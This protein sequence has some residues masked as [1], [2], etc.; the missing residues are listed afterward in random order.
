VDEEAIV[1]IVDDEFA[2]RDLVRRTVAS[3]GL[4]AECFASG[5]EFLNAYDASRVACLVTDLRLP[6]LTGQEI[7][8][9]LATRR[10]MLPTVVIS[11][12]GDIPSAV[13]AMEVGAITFLEK[14]CSL[15]RLQESIQ[16]AITRAKWL[17]EQSHQA[18]AIQDR[19]S[20]LND[21]EHI[22]MRMIAEGKPDKAIASRLDVSIRTVQ[23]RRASLM[24]KLGV[25][26]RAQLIRITPRDAD[27][28]I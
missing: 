28:A 9:T 8:E 5:R 18:R 12:Y 7:L 14:P 25:T 13:R 2:M 21:E 15:D 23:L 10:A 22:T 6:D 27:A 24:N 3:I 19:L 17:H 11:G 20:T 16:V 4:N 1:Y 26:T